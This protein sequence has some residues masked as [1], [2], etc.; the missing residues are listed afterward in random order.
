MRRYLLLLTSHAFAGDQG[1]LAADDVAECGLGGPLAGVDLGESFTDGARVRGLA[2]E[3]FEHGLDVD[4]A[5]VEAQVREEVE[6]SDGAV[7][8]VEEPRVVFA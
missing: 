7:A 8:E 2:V 1:V 3:C 5:R 6:L 4:A